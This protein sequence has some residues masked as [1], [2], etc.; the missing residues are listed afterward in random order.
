MALTG[1]L[2]LSGCTPRDP[3]LCRLDKVRDGDSLSVTC[4]NQR[5]EVRLYCIDAPELAQRPWGKQSRTAL[6][7]FT[8]QT[9]ALK[10]QGKDRFGRLVAEVINADGTNLNLAQLKDGQAAMYRHYC[11]RNNYDAAE[12]SAQKA[13][14]G[15]W[16]KPGQQQR[17]WEYRRKH[18]RR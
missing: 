5:Q 13:H 6:R 10:V 1:T 17:P 11:K 4:G 14:R 15:I 8:G 12:Q 2:L 7:R 16:S 9:I 3:A 18:L